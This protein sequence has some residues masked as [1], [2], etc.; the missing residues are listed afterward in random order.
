MMTA[1][2]YG[3]DGPV[4]A[5]FPFWAHQ[6]WA[7]YAGY[8][9]K[10]VH[11]VEYSFYHDLLT[12]QIN[13][14]RE[15]F[16][17]TGESGTEK[18]SCEVLDMQVEALCRSWLQQGVVAG[19]SIV[20]AGFSGAVRYA[21]LLAALRL[22]LIVS[23]LEA[24]GPFR[25]NHE[26]DLLAPDH[27][28]LDYGIRVW[29]AAEYESKLLHNTRGDASLEVYSHAYPSGAP[30]LRLLSCFAEGSSS[31]MT[32]SSDQLFMALV[33]DGH[34]L[35]G[36]KPDDR[37]ICMGDAAL[38]LAPLLELAILFCGARLH[39]IS[40]QCSASHTGILFDEPVHW[41]FIDEPSRAILMREPWLGK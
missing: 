17:Y 8:T 39:S 10:S 36:L 31:I 38:M 18:I 13:G 15:F 21:A 1:G 32:L 35:M 25:L 40:P 29:L 30:V 28:F 2:A 4:S 19:S 5:D 11:G 24:S 27:I 23:L 37:V 34:L 20:L 9:G 26:V 12:R 14:M 22:G 41:V 6:Q 3:P 7:Q 16:A 33:R